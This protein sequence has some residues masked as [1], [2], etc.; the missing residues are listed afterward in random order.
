[1]KKLIAAFASTTLIL[2]GAAS[3]ETWSPTGPVSLSNIGP[4]TVSK[5]ITLTCGV[6]GSG[7]LNGSNATVNSL[8]LTGGLCGNVRFTSLPYNLE[9]TSPTS[10]TLQNVVVTAI[11]GN[12]AGDLTGSFN[13]STGVITFSGATIPSNPAGGAPCVINGQV[14]TNPAASFTIP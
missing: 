8:A 1:M 4:V 2:A 10:V 7:T 14:A 11:T 12:C 9:G 6:S 13:Q 5:G 3:A